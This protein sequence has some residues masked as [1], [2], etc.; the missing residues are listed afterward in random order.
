M[1]TKEWVYENQHGYGL[2]QDL[3]FE[4]NNRNPAVVEVSNPGAFSIYYE[5]NLAAEPI[6]RLTAEIPAE[7]FDEI[8]IAWCRKRKLHGALGGP[9]GQEWGTGL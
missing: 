9:V 3:S 2:Y 1:S 8:A 5:T 6:G 4:S 7:V